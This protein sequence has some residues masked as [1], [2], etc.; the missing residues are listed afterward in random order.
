VAGAKVETKKSELAELKKQL[1]ATQSH[2]ETCLTDVND[3]LARLHVE[4]GEIK[5]SK[6]ELQSAKNYLEEQLRLVRMQSETGEGEREVPNGE[7]KRP[8][9]NQLLMEFEAVKN[10][11]EALEE[12]HKRSLAHVRELEEL[13]G[14]KVSG[15]EFLN[16]RFFKNL[17]FLHPSRNHPITVQIAG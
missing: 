13:V 5:S 17:S 6:A 14:V 8:A 16:S 1:I 4:V 15:R 11:Y 10:S 2:Y 9:S 7:G 3:R 12:E